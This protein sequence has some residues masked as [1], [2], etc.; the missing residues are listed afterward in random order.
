MTAFRRAGLV[1]LTVLL[2]AVAAG[3]VG[4]ATSRPTGP[5]LRQ[6]AAP[7]VAAPVAQ[8]VAQEAPAAA[9]P[10]PTPTPHRRARPRDVPA[11]LAGR[12]DPHAWSRARRCSSAATTG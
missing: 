2:L 3:A 7:P 9:A 5:D 10:K 1:L 11:P 4:Y 12:P 6:A 8:E